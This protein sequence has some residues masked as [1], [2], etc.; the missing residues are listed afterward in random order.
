MVFSYSS[1]LAIFV[2]SLQLLGFLLLSKEATSISIGAVSSATW[3][4]TRSFLSS[5]S[6]GTPREAYMDSSTPR[7]SGEA[8][9]KA[10]EAISMNVAKVEVDE[11]FEKQINYSG[12]IRN[13][14]LD[15]ADDMPLSTAATVTKD[16]NG[17]IFD[18]KANNFHAASSN[19]R[20]LNAPGD[21]P[22]STTAKKTTSRKCKP[23]K[24]VE[25]YSGTNMKWEDWQ[26]L[27]DTPGLLKGGFVSGNPLARLHHDDKPN[28]TYLTT[29]GLSKL[30]ILLKS[31]CYRLGAPEHGVLPMVVWLL[32]NERSVEAKA[33]LKEITP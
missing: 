19:T 33:V 18:K 23:S 13:N 14:A 17:E 12:V 7:R 3:R 9:A 29:D 32:N 27:A 30:E 24:W 8:T 1:R 10:K 25:A 15:S 5:F 26:V 22:L 28:E 4:A 11:V 6:H 31:G 20:S 2:V 21:K 16:E